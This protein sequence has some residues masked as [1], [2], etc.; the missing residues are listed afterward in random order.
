M[1]NPTFQ[2]QYGPWALVT[3]ASSGIGRHIAL[4]LAQ[5]GL[6]VILVARNRV[7]LEETAMMV[8][9]HGTQAHVLVADFEQPHA[10]QE[11]LEAVSG[12]EVGLLVPAAGFGDAG[13]FA[14]S[15]L[16]LQVAMVQVNI[17]SVMVLTHHF[18]R[19]MQVQGRGGIVLIASLLAFHGTPYSANYAATKAYVQ[20]LGEALAVE[21]KGTGVDVLVSS[22]GPTETGFGQRARMQMGKAMTAQEVATATL[23]ALGRS[24]TV[25]PGRLTKLLRGALMTAPRFLQV[26]II[27]GMMKGFARTH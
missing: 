8:R 26:R 15:D 23:A 25:L 1:H 11:V 24:G 20:S 3:G 13:L 14:E 12:Y 9:T 5:K 2:K 17:T 16:A 27:G 7:L 18:A 4:L 22:P 10:A 6:H 19:R 21:L